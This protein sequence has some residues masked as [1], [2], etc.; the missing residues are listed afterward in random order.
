LILRHDRPPEVGKV[1]GPDESATKKS[2]TPTGAVNARSCAS[3]PACSEGR[4]TSA[5]IDSYLACMPSILHLRQNPRKDTARFCSNSLE[6]HP[7]RII[8]LPLR[9]SLI[10]KISRDNGVQRSVSSAGYRPTSVYNGLLNR[11][12]PPELFT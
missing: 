8:E 6:N 2:H 12:V 9:K 1:I 11:C 4:A 3:S 7:N 5:T 10:L